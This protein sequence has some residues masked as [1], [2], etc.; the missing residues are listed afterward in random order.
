MK[1]PCLTIVTQGFKFVGTQL[2]D[3]AT[4][5][6]EDHK[7]WRPLWFHP[8]A[9]YQNSIFTI[10]CFY[11]KPQNDKSSLSRVL[12]H[13]ISILD[14]ALPASACPFYGWHAARVVGIS[15]TGVL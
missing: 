8:K 6:N 9:L 1:K 11:I 12:N 3:E 5:S 2:F 13:Q 7:V 4:S 15:V 14:R 10:I